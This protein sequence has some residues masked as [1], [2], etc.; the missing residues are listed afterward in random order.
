MTIP[1]EV[2]VM[3]DWF[4]KHLGSRSSGGGHEDAATK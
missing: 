4:D 3:A 2:K 1:Q